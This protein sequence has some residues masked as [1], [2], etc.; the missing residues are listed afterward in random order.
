MH[1]QLYH[2]RCSRSQRI[3]WLLEELEL[4]YEL[5]ICN[6]LDTHEAPDHLKKIHPLGKAPILILQ[7]PTEKIVLAESASMCQ[8]LSRYHHQLG[9]PLQPISAQAYFDYWLHFSEAT[10]LSNLVLKQVFYQIKCKTPFPLRFISAL[11]KQGL[12]HGFL[13]A[14]LHSYFKMADQHLATHIYFAGDEFSIVDILMWFPLS[15]CLHADKS[16]QQYLHIQRYLQHIENRPAFQ[17]ACIKGEW[18]SIQFQQYW[19]QAWH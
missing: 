17:R 5:I 10:F 15:A 13:N 16:V 2:L 18:S 7:S 3:V 14:T 12:D 1:I 19:R 6:Q 11:I 9:A 4:S 8:F